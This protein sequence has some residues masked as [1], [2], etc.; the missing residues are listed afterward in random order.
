MDF[1]QKMEKNKMNLQTISVFGLLLEKFPFWVVYCRQYGFLMIHSH[2]FDEIR[3]YP[4]SIC[5]M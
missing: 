2:E 4:V 5:S 3:A 1:H